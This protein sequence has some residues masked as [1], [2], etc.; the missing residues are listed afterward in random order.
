M[1]CIEVYRHRNIRQAFNTEYSR[2]GIVLLT[3][4][5]MSTVQEATRTRLEFVLGL[6]EDSELRSGLINSLMVE[7]DELA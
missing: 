7:V 6:S 5:F 4:D 3:I 1:N 2:Y